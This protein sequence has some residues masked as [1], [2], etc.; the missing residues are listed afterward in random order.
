[1][2]Q[3]ITAEFA[4][5][6]TVRSCQFNS[7]RQEVN[8]SNHINHN[9]CLH[10]EIVRDILQERG[11]IYG[12]AQEHFARTCGL[13]SVV[14]HVQKLEKMLERA[15]AG[16]CPFEHSDWALIMIL[17]KIGRYSNPRSNHDGSH[18]DTIQDITGYSAIMSDLYQ[19]EARRVDG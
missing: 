3:A 15:K 7:D 5:E 2:G 19:R 12:P 11:Q 10:L 18:T 17:E 13:L 6:G 9:A 1:M 4:Q 14:F 16:L 8:M